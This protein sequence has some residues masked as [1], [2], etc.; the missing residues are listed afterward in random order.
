MEERK[1]IGQITIGY[2]TDN[3]KKIDVVDV[4]QSEILQGPRQ[5]TISKLVDGSYVLHLRS[6]LTHGHR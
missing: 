3:E 5:V 4:I 1:A 2:G 6:E